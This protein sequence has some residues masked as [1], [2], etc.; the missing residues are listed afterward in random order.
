[1]ALF[2][3]ALVMGTLLAG[4]AAFAGHGLLAAAL[5]AAVLAAAWLAGAAVRVAAAHGTVVSGQD[6]GYADRVTGLFVANG[7]LGPLAIGL[8]VLAL[9]RHARLLPTAAVAVALG[10]ADLGLLAAMLA[11]HGLTWQFTS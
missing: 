3:V 5:V 7:V 2:L 11:S 8:G 10:V 6:R 1:M 4:S 9:R